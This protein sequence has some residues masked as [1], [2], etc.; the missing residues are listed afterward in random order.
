M[1]RTRESTINYLK[2]KRG[3]KIIGSWRWSISVHRHGKP[4]IFFTPI[5]LFLNF[6]SGREREREW[7]LSRFVADCVAPPWEKEMMM[8]M[9][10]HL[11]K[12]S[13]VRSIVFF[14]FYIFRKFLL[15][16]NHRLLMGETR[17]YNMMGYFP[18][19]WLISE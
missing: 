9:P 6:K 15:L 17:L 11:K 3:I 5:P 16:K 4:R 8:M 12:N 13:L 18:M 14:F 19:G 7:N 10:F 2:A 1:T